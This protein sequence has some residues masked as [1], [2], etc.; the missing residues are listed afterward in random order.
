MTS[1]RQNY[2]KN[3]AETIRQLQTENQILKAKVA[4]LEK[5]LGISGSSGSSGSS[6]N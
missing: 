4:E 5:R 3:Q 6:G 1:A 2:R